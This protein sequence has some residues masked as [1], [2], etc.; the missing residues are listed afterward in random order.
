MES[1]GVRELSVG[2]E[3]MMMIEGCKRLQGGV[4]VVEQ[5]VRMWR[6]ES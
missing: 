1:S 2:L 5:K 3:A 6:K 4:K